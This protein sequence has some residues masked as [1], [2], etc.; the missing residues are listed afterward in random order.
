M[1][2]KLQILFTL[3]VF[4]GLHEA[5]AQVS[6]AP[7]VTYP[8][9]DNPE[10]FTFADVNGDG[11]IDLICGNSGGSPYNNGTLSILTNNGA[12]DF[13]LASTV[14]LGH[15]PG[16]IAA[17]DITGNGNVDLI[18][19]N[20]D[21][22]NG[23][24]LSIWTN[25]GSGQFGSNATLNVGSG[26][27]S[28]TAADIYGNGKLALICANCG[29]SGNGNTLT[30]LTNNGN[31]I[32]GSNATYVVGSGPLSVM[33]AD[34]NG[35]GKIDL[36][37]A[38]YGNGNG[39]TLT[40]LTNNGKGI[41]GSN[42][43]YVV[44]AGPISVVAADL[45]GNGK[46]D[47]V[48]ADEGSANGN[49]L[50]VLTNNGNG[51]FSSNA[52][53]V[54][55]SVPHSVMAADLDGDGKLDLI[56]ANF[57]GN[58]SDGGDLSVLTNNGNGR[59][60]LATTLTTSTNSNESNFPASVVAIHL[61]GDGKSDLACVNAAANTVAVLE[62]TTIFSPPTSRPALSINLRGNESEVS[63]PLPSPGWSLQQNTGLKAANWGP[64]GYNGYSISDDGTNYNLVMP[65][66]SGNLFFR[67]IHP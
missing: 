31:G 35:D 59:F 16:S 21:N 60:F 34:L 9:G 23:S 4:F 6:F 64:G 56:S 8:V 19:A 33:A 25:N 5:A 45:N 44:G 29:P 37:C 58:G 28:V 57:L 67:L 38:N 10:S 3:A 22:G 62:N 46:I 30:V 20:W 40:V 52:T 66:Q 13:T 7:A 61:N 63:W 55:G 27:Y 15:G 48:C 32:F 24:T 1:R 2:T 11:K 18:T 14:A 54:V 12:G 39:N 42:A 53:Y 50:M 36:V 17:A 65:A 49:T 41:F 43:T 47:L 26:P 51:I